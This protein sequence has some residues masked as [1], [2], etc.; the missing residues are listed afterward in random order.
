MPGSTVAL[1]LSCELLSAMLSGS[2]TPCSHS[3]P[4]AEA[5]TV[6][7]EHALSQPS[8]QAVQSAS[9]PTSEE[10]Q[11]GLTTLHAVEARSWLGYCRA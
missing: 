8:V 2:P 5:L 3:S 6:G 7:V 9:S 4:L 10:L 1:F 11:V